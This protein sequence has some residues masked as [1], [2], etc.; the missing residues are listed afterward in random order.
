MHLVDYI[1]L[2]LSSGYIIHLKIRYEIV[3]LVRLQFWNL[4]LYDKKFTFSMR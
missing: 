2:A 4:V 3:H 1:I